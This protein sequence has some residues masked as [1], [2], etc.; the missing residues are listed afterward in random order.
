MFK[1]DSELQRD[2]LDELKWDPIVDHSHIGVTAKGGV[3]TLSGFVPTYAEKMAAEAA[4]R[5]VAGVRAIAEE[6]EVRF[7]NDPKASD[8]EIAQRI[9]DVFSW[10]TM[11]PH[12][13]LK[14]KVER[15]F[16][17]LTGEVQWYYQKEVAQKAAGRI[18]GVKSVTN[19]ISVKAAPSAIDV[20]ERIQAAI[21]RSSALDAGAIDVMVEGSTVKLSGRV[22]GWNERRV[23]ENA[24]WAAPGVTRVEDN[25][26][27]A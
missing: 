26:V 20:R 12:E 1:T 5:R 24:A 15:G 18:S 3:V 2:V 27:F 21:K 25:I 10:N 14:V 23:A 4:A 16:V 19:R 22:H 6:I 8:A 13:A 9:L 7:A 17:T 11:I